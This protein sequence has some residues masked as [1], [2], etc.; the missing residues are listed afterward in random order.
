MTH[1]NGVPR[2]AQNTTLRRVPRPNQYLHAHSA[3]G[4]IPRMPLGYP[5]DVGTQLNQSVRF[6]RPGALDAD[7]WIEDSTH[8]GPVSTAHARL[9]DLGEKHGWAGLRGRA[10]TRRARHLPQHAS[11]LERDQKSII[12]PRIGSEAPLKVIDFRDRD[13]SAIHRLFGRIIG[14]HSNTRGTGEV[15]AGTMFVTRHHGMQMT[16]VALFDYVEALWEA[17][18]MPHLGVSHDPAARRVLPANQQ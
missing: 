1:S 2:A 18:S 17:A 16:L 4:V 15:I 7:P 3:K 8:K 11:S 13:S 5:C 6:P 9:L 10:A 14:A 12:Y